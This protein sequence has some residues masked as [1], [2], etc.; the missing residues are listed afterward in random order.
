MRSINLYKIWLFLLRDSQLSIAQPSTL[1]H[2][3]SIHGGGQ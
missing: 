2:S 3:L 1:A